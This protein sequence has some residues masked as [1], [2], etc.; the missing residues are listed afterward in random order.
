MLNLFV[1]LA[2]RHGLFVAVCTL[3]LAGFELMICA[4]VATVDITGVL[5]QLMKSAPPFMQSML[6]KEFFG[7]LTTR[8]MVAFGWNH[9]I[10]LAPGAAIAIVL[11]ARAIAGEIENGAMELV[12]SQPLPRRAYLVTHW[13]FAV[14]SLLVLSLG[15]MCGTIAGQ[16][17]Y[18]VPMFDSNALL[19]VAI[20]FFLLQCAWFGVT[21]V[22]SVFGREGGRVAGA[23]FLLALLAYIISV[24]GRLLASVAFLLPY[25]LYDYYS[26]QG[27]LIEFQPVGVSFSVL[28]AVSVVCLGFVAWRFEKRDIP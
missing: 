17:L 28:F 21:S 12:L 10:A 11:A 22:F 14:A 6:G 4:L 9:P 5:E 27:I 26:P 8:G 24:I 2:R 18:N 20:N 15:G 25:S 1:Q 3:L 13:A 19:K 7:A 16:H 23:V